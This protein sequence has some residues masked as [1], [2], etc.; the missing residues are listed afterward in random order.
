MFGR[1]NVHTESCKVFVKCNGKFNLIKSIEDAHKLFANYCERIGTDKHISFTS[2]A[3]YNH[4]HHSAY[5]YHFPS[6]SNSI[7]NYSYV[8]NTYNCNVNSAQHGNQ[9]HQSR[10]G[11]TYYRGSKSSTGYS[12]RNRSYK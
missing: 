1:Y 2:S 5:D 6:H 8:P 4:N 7:N 11:R 9:R 12:V 3:A 10:R